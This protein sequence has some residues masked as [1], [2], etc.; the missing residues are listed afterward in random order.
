MNTITVQLNDEQFYALQEVI[1]HAMDRLEHLISIEGDK[2]CREEFE[3]E[4]S[5][6]GE[7]AGAINSTKMYLWTSG[8]G[9]IELD[10]PA[11]IVDEVAQ[12]GDNLPAVESALQE[13]PYIVK[14]MERYDSKVLEEYLDEA[15]IDDVHQMNIRTMHQYLLWMACWDI[16]EERNSGD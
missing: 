12:S 8:C 6:A 7:L 9:R 13:H 1:P 10:I 5:T 2:E 11:S 16:H 14:Q 15:G 4:L 3:T